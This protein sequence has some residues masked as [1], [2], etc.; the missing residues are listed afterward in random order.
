MIVL[1]AGTK[2][3][4]VEESNASSKTDKRGI[5]SSTNHVDRTPLFLN[6]PH[7][8]PLSWAAWVGV[9]S[10]D[11]ADARLVRLAVDV[12]L[13]A[14]NGRDGGVGSDAQARAHHARAVVVVPPRLLQHHGVG[15]SAVL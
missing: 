2:R 8:V 9:N 1:P 5:R 15:P 4:E 13:G 6:P 11:G 7:H 10:H 14:S 12:V 3:E